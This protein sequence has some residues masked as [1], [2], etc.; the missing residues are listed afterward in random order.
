MR[1]ITYAEAIRESMCQEF[2]KNEDVFI[3][4]EDIGVFGGA[5]GVTKGMVEEFG[6][7]RVR[8][9]PISEMAIGGCA[10]GAAMSGLRPIL[11]LQFSDFMTYALDSMANQAAKMSYMFAGDVKVPMVV[12]LPSGSGLGFAF[13]H[14]QSLEAWVAHVPGLKVVQPSSPYDA[15]GLLKAAMDDDNPVLFF[16]HKALYGSK[17]DVPEE[18]YSIELGKGEI[19]RNGNDITIVA[20]GIMVNRSLEAA[21]QLEK[22]G[23]S[24]EVVDPRTLVPLDEE[25]ILNSVRKTGRVI[26]AHE[27]VKRGGYGAEIASMIAE[28]DA[29][30]YLDAPIIRVAGLPVPIPF[31]PNL[32]KKAVPQVEEIIQAV[33]KNL[34]NE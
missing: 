14:S 33:K 7:E 23:I 17:G 19:K 16:E 20:T 24:V 10:V 21:E 9:T 2:R 31:S 25:I 5:F 1:E 13:Q 28:S 4:G 12:R 15:K 3:L 26:V 29:F 22:E 27:A 34:N 32:E 8:D 18:P 6:K 30:D 11:E